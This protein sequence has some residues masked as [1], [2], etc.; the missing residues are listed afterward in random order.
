MHAHYVAF[1]WGCVYCVHE[2]RTYKR[3]PLVVFMTSQNYQK[4]P[5]FTRR[6]VLADVSEM[7]EPMSAFTGPKVRADKLLTETQIVTFVISSLVPPCGVSVQSNNVTFSHRKPGGGQEIFWCPYYRFRATLFLCSRHLNAKPFLYT[8]S[9]HNF[10]TWRVSFE[11]SI[12]HSH[13]P[14]T[15][16]LVLL[17]SN[18]GKKYL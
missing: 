6:D 8:N 5:R 3:P 18:L 13:A 4:P 11:G 14:C 9:Q 1:K 15:C 7:S 10:T 17:H 16:V 2:K 12:N